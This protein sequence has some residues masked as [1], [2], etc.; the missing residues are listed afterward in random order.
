M[1]D[2]KPSKQELLPEGDMADYIKET[3][4]PDSPAFIGAFQEKGG[5]IKVYVYGDHE[6]LRFYLECITNSIESYLATTPPSG[7]T[8]ELQ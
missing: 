3:M 7:T 4:D 1:A 2:L 6:S 5:E 8:E